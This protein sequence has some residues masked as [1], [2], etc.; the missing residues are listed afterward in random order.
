MSDLK[1]YEKKW[2]AILD[3]PISRVKAKLQ[4]KLE[5]KKIRAEMEKRPK[6]F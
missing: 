1:I 2:Q 5:L 4:A 6:K 3:S